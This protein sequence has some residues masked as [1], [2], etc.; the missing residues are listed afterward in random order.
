MSHFDPELKSALDRQSEGVR[1][2]ADLAERAI[3]RDRSNRRRELG[4]AAL[5][6]GLVLAIAVPLGWGAVRGNSPR[7]LPIGPSVS[8]TVPAD[9]TR[10]AP[11][12]TAPTAPTS[13]PTTPATIP[14]I[15]STGAPGSAVLAPADGPA[16]ATTDVGY[17][18]DG[19]FHLGPRTIPLGPGLERPSRVALLGDGLLVQAGSRSAV[20][21]ANGRTVRNLAQLQGPVE[22]D[23][24]GRRALVTDADGNLL[25]LDD[26]GDELRR[27]AA[28][29][30]SDAGWT[31]VHLGPSVAYALTS[32]RASTLVWDL[33]SGRT[34]TMKGSVVTVDPLGTRAVVTDPSIPTEDPRHWCQRLV[35]LESTRTLWT[36][37]GPLTLTSFSADGAHLLGTG[38]SDGM[39]PEISNGRTGRPLYQQLVVVRAEDG[40]VV[41]QGGGDGALATGWVHRARFGPNG[42][43]TIKFGVDGQ[44]RNLQRCTIDGDCEVVG[45]AGSPWEP[46]IGPDSDGPYVMAES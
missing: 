19:V 17:V 8:T 18:R 32:D 2:V 40:R 26:T 10:T 6:A 5:A 41:L 33:A 14:T 13:A 21:D 7:P 34:S 31:A 35:D 36:M 29:R 1:V 43:L 46:D 20:V 28:A 15:R 42:A 24:D 11:P 23:P 45:E 3:A 9:P 44:K 22:V 30:A 38:F 4:G 27:L 12:T 25:L 37:C 39:P 16:T